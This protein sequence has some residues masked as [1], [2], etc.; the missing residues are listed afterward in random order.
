MSANRDAAVVVAG[1]GTVI[2]GFRNARV[3][4]DAAVAW[5]DGR[6]LEVGPAADLDRKHAGGRRLDAAGGLILP[7]LVNLHHHFYSSLARGLNPGLELGDFGEILSGLWWRID[8]ALDPETVRLSAELAAAD[9]I[10]W[11]ATTVFD[12][13]ASPSFI[14]G[15]LQTIADAVDGA[16]L[17]AVL[18]Y[19]ITDRNGHP[20]ALDGLAENLEFFETHRADPRIRGM[21]GLHASFTVDDAT[22]AAAASRP[23]EMGCHIHLAEDPL[24]L[25]VSKLAHG[26]DPV[27]RLIEHGLVDD[28][29]LAVHGL[30]LGSDDRRLL[31][32]RGAVL[33]HN[34]ESNANNGVGRLDLDSAGADGCRIGLGTDGMSSAMLGSLRAA[35]LGLR[36][37]RCDPTLGFTVI[38][39]LLAVN[40]ET[41]GRFLDEPQL[42]R[43]EP[44]APADLCVLDTAPPTPVTSE[45]VFAHLVYGCA[46]TTVRHTVARGRVLLEDHRFTTLD[47]RVT[48]DQARAAAPALWERFHAL[49]TTAGLLNAD[50]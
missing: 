8:R 32:E 16:G 20:D 25:R 5:K 50:H 26:A 13:H 33:V 3:H 42:G 9:C 27:T 19:E 17:S 45:N 4:T 40:A 46:V 15:S 34:P 35:F 12:H 30:H 23:T 47:P 2:T 41:A 39:E 38:P 18:C 43:L 28:R 37:G 7:G 36:G 31:A 44:G 22:L 29:C 21:L 49:R 14:H 10:R 6:V 11:G 48:A 24:D 1:P